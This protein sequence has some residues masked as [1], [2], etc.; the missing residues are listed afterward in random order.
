M[1]PIVLENQ[2][3]GTPRTVWDL[4]GPGSAN[5]EGFTTDISINHGDTVD[6][7]IN[8]GSTNYRIEIYRLGYYGGEGARLITTI[9]HQSPSALLQPAPLLDSATGLVDAGNWQ[10]TDSWNIPADAVSGIYIAKL[11]RADGTF[12][13][14]HIPFIVRDDGG[15][16]DI[17]FQTDDATWQAYNYWGGVSL[18]P[19]IPGAIQVP[20]VSYNRP[21]DAL[22]FSYYVNMELPAIMWLEKNGYDVSYMTNVDTARNGSLLLDHKVFLTIGKDEYWS[23]EQYANVQA[24]RDAGVNLQFWTGNDIFWKTEWRPS[25]DGSN[26]DFRTL[27]TYKESQLGVNPSGGWTGL[28]A[29]PNAPE[30]INPP[31]AL[32]G[33]LF[34]VLETDPYLSAIEIPYEQSQ[35]RFW[36]NTSI[37]DT[38]PGGIAALASTYLGPEWNSDQ[39]NGFR[40][41]GLID[42]SETTVGTK[43]QVLD[44]STNASGPGVA[45][46][47]L[48]LYRAPSGALVFAAGSM[49]W[50]WALDSH[51]PALLSQNPAPDPNVQQ[52]M[53]NLFA[54]MGVQPAT[55]QSNLV[56]ASPSTDTAAP[57][58]G[59]AELNV[60]FSGD[61]ALTL[62]GSASDLGGGRVA[63]I[64]VSTN[65]GLQWH[66]AIGGFSWT[67]SASG[68]APTDVLARG[69]DDSLNIGAPDLVPANVL[70]RAIGDSLAGG[71]ARAVATKDT[72]NDQPWSVVWNNYDA[73]G[74][75]DQQNIAFDDGSRA[76]A[77]LDSSNSNPW[78]LV[79]DN[80][81][82]AGNWELQ[83][84]TFDDG[85][86]A[87]AQ[88]DPLNNQP[89]SLVWDNYDIAGNWE[90]QSLTFDDGTLAVAQLDPLN[91]QPWSLVWDNYDAA[92]LWDTQAIQFD[93]G[94]RAWSD[95]DQGNTS[96]W[97]SDNYIY[98]AN[99]NL[100]SHFQVMDDGIVVFP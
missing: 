48:T 52:G 88:L 58:V 25:I 92:G 22:T 9:Q 7:K 39:D 3:P 23:A 77:S 54:D 91:N 93:D 4:S 20:A 38:Q 61:M 94:T 32:T 79:W 44:Y 82:I 71:S 72:L 2:L 45:T 57:S 16:S 76:V 67:Y 10:V 80:Y 34:E 99:N 63:G 28:W 12:G 66:P 49:F 30:G 26:T 70:G 86:L 83:S 73:T 41:A 59:I 46:H 6:F 97:Y 87:M 51:H 13:E 8:T 33:S 69:V 24:A 37:A 89:W 47:N 96:D 68:A 64:E 98:D 50:S 42:L 29:N 15:Q 74:N 90:L 1:N 84:L 53:V 62:T 17:V 85:T 40:P 19:N 75:W 11:V 100:T 95:L 55:L 78:S 21:M 65:G 5:I 31:N 35:F 14:N 36:R 43:Y 81:D 56:A 60:D 18:Y 27:V